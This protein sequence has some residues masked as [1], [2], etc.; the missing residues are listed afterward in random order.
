MTQADQKMRPIMERAVNKLMTELQTGKV[1]GE[2]I[3]ADADWNHRFEV[4]Q[5]PGKTTARGGQMM[6]DLKYAGSIKTTG[7]N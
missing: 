7:L 4:L 3:I 5:L 1:P 6:F 2:I